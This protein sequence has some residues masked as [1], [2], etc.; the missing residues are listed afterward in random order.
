LR[1]MTLALLRVT[2]G[3][4]MGKGDRVTCELNRVVKIPVSF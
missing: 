1:P 4:G 3:T 2:V